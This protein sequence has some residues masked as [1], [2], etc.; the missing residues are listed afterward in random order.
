MSD[1]IV[2]ARKYRPET[3]K[4]VVGQD[5]ITAT[6]KN[7]ISGNHLGHAYLFC[8][9]HGVGK[10][11]CARI[12][13]K[14]INCQ[15]IAEDG[16]A[17][18]ECESCVSFNESRSYNIHELDA[19]SNN[20]VDDIRSL[21][22]QVRIPPQLGKY[23]VYII[24]EVHMLS[25]QAFNAFLKTLEEPPKHAIFI[26]AT[27]EKHK[28]IP[29]ILSR[30]QIFDFNRIKVQDTV[31]Y[32]SFIAGEETIKFESDA[33]HVIAQKADGAMR[34]ALSIFDQVVSFSGGNIE[35]QTVIDNL[36]ILDFEYY[37]KLTDHFLE[38]ETSEPLLIFDE[39]LDKGFDSHNF[40]NGL[41]S[42][43][44]D[45]LVSTDK[46]TIRLLEVSDNLKEK[47]LNQSQ[48]VTPDFLFTVL[49]ICAQI[50]LQFKASRNQRLL[51]E[52]GLIKMANLIAEKKKPLAEKAS[53]QE[54][55]QVE[56]P[57]EKTVKSESGE[58]S[59]NKILVANEN[60][61]DVNSSDD[62][63]S[64]AITDVSERKELVEKKSDE[65]KGETQNSEVK[66]QRNVVKSPVISIR[67]A[68][69]N[70]V[71]NEKIEEDSPG[72]VEG[73]IVVTDDEIVHNE[74]FTAV[75]LEK[76]WGVYVEKLQ[77]EKPRI[78]SSLK[79][80]TPFLNEELNVE[81]EF[82]NLDQLENFNQQ[83][84]NSLQ[85]HLKR[86]LKNSG[87]EIIT[88]LKESDTKGKR[89]YTSEEKF[90][91]LSKKNPNIVKLKQQFNLDFD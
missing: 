29:T 2:S 12:F 47:Y 13:A 64:T 39:I 27:T 30:C 8:G 82:V 41:A 42:H 46:Q 80:R 88:T 35:Y 83:V 81:L 15:S 40:I 1:F 10:T 25:Q 24:D 79:S 32:L 3:F 85:N 53:S 5:S 11:T 55:G 71:V 90:D 36:N 66:I 20:T 45:L 61:K 38:G 65:K 50:D 34:D 73:E 91:Y 76:S 78:Y 19:A 52:L 23:S 43:F 87:I 48:K 16:E 75:E 17:C 37:F 31:E 74:H 54:A 59:E 63:L 62:K 21:N 6:L 44:R 58:L 72:A 18:N 67:S 57:I 49:D 84:R 33:L 89:L 14:T 70:K 7:A 51:I 69:E 68:L 60:L 4:S 56:I 22:E 28:I 26:L 86:E 9:P 77:N